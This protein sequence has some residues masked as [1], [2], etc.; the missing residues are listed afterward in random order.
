MTDY[1]LT[2]EIPK[3][4]YFLDFL[5]DPVS[6]TIIRI[7][8]VLIAVVYVSAYLYIRIRKDKKDGEK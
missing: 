3:A 5:N 7:A 6:I 1:P 4:H 2:N 8:A